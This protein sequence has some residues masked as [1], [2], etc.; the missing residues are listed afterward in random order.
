MS[1]FSTG[2]SAGIYAKA[3]TDVFGIGATV[4][5]SGAFVDYTGPTIR[6]VTSN[7]AGVTTAYGGSLAQDTTN[8]TIYVNTSQT[9]TRGTGWAELGRVA[10]TNGTMFTKVFALPAPVDNFGAN[11][12]TLQSFTSGQYS[13]PANTLQ[14]SSVIRVRMY[15]S[16]SQAAAQTMTVAFALGASA[17]VS[18]AAIGFANGTAFVIDFSCTIRTGAT[19]TVAALS[20]NT[21]ATVVNAYSA[22]GAAIDTTIANTLTMGVTFSAA[23]A[24]THMDIGGY[25]VY[26]AR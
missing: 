7:P 17:L 25:E 22:A 9:G 3:L 10:A 14:A 8:G 18:Q 15:G 13:I 26:I 19:T 23:A 11:T 4:N 24:G 6:R 16:M 2:S 20:G 5:S 12:N 1:V 21:S